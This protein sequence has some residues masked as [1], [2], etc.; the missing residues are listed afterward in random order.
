MT[1]SAD[2][3]GF[4]GSAQVVQPRLAL[5]WQALEKGWAWGTTGRVGGKQIAVLPVL[6]GGKFFLIL[7]WV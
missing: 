7:P 2:S 1:L 6:W 3:R 5:A 4:Q